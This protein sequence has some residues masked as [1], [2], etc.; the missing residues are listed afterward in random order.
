[1]TLEEYYK[2]KGVD[3]SQTDSKKE[4]VKKGEVKADWI[5]K[6]KLEVLKTKED[7][8]AEEET[9]AKGKKRNV[10]VAGLTSANNEMFGFGVKPQKK[11]EPREEIQQREHK[12]GKD[13]QRKG[14]Q[15]RQ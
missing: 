14:P 15:K 13:H 6:E 7:K 1:M 8:K 4:P 5:K 11:Q 3:L 12:G 2:A 9:Q 10:E